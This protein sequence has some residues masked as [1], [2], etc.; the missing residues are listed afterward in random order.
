MSK[1]LVPSAYKNMLACQE[2]NDR[3]VKVKRMNNGKIEN[4]PCRE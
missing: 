3:I 2:N 4:L 1:T